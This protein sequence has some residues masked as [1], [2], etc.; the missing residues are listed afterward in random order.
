MKNQEI[1]V[2]HRFQDSIVTSLQA[3][4]LMAPAFSAAKAQSVAG[5][6]SPQVIKRPVGRNPFTLRTLTVRTVENRPKLPPKGNDYL[7][8]HCIF[9]VLDIIN[10]S[11]SGFGG[12]VPCAFG[13]Q[14]KN[15]GF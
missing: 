15:A 8:T 14:W 3:H 9:R 13:P 4:P 11:V 7:P 1:L 5:T 12:T 10:L 6:P 2:R